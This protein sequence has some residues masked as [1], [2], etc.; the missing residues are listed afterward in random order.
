MDTP[1]RLK[2]AGP[3]TRT[4][5]CVANGNDL[6]LAWRFVEDDRKGI[7]I[8]HNSPRSMKIVRKEPWLLTHHV[9]SRE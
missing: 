3:I 8:K 5:L 1:R 6:N 4:A 9:Y 7:A 2:A